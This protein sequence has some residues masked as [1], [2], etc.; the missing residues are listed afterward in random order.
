MG[1]LTLS[2]TQQG[3]LMKG[4]PDDARSQIIGERQYREWHSLKSDFASASLTAQP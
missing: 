2:R 1:L 4:Q 3:N